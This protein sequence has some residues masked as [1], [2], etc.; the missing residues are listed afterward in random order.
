MKFDYQGIVDCHETTPFEG[1]CYSGMGR[2][3]WSVM[4]SGWN[5]PIDNAPMNGDYI[6]FSIEELS[7]VNFRSIDKKDD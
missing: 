7:T 2:C 5:R 6:A 3:R 1:V 4:S